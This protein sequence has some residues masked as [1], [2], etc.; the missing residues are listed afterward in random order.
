MG[1]EK[2]EVQWRKLMRV[3]NH[4]LIPEISKKGY[5]LE[6]RNIKK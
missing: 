4:L 1:S 3:E 5:D 6:V 2:P